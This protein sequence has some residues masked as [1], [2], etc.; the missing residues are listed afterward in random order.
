MK[1]APLKLAWTPVS[2][3]QKNQK[4]PVW[5]EELERRRLN[6]YVASGGF[7]LN[8]MNAQR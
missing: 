1:P 8:N 5:Q 3:T 4:S 2:V 7:W 6:P